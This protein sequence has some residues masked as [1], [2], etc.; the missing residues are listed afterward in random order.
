MRSL[1]VSAWQV[2]GSKLKMHCVA[3]VAHG[4]SLYGRARRVFARCNG[5]RRCWR[6]CV[7]RYI[8]CFALRLGCCSTCACPIL[9]GRTRRLPSSAAGSV[10]IAMFTNLGILITLS[11]LYVFCGHGYDERANLFAVGNRCAKRCG[12]PARL[13]AARPGG[14]KCWR[15]YRKAV[16]RMVCSY[17]CGSDADT[18]RKQSAPERYNA[19]SGAL[20]CRRKPD[21]KKS[22]R[23]VPGIK[24]RE[25]GGDGSHR[26]RKQA[27]GI[28]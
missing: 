16:R 6:C 17:L 21:D 20:L 2:L 23:R 22:G 14:E 10:V 1:P 13:G 15:E 9:T 26:K 4:A 11:L 3:Y 19:A 24:R 27:A 12:R 5:L 28:S 8:R 7:R 18:L 25:R